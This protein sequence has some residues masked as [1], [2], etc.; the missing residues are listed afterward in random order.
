MMLSSN[1]LV[2]SNRILKRDLVIVDTENKIVIDGSEMPDNNELYDENE[3]DD[4]GKIEANR[5]EKA[6]SSAE[7]I[8]RQAERQAEE[9][10]INARAT[11]T[12]ESTAIR[13]EAKGEAARLAAEAREL[14]YKEGLDKAFQ[15]GE[16]IKSNAEKVLR[17]AQN[18]RIRMQQDFE[19]EMVEL[20]TQIA[21]KLLG[22]IPELSPSIIVN[23]IKQGF[24]AAT[25][26]G[27]VKVYVSQQD[28]DAVLENQDEL[29][30]ITDG[31]VKLEIVKDL[32]LSPMDCVIETPFG[33]VDCSLGQQFEAIKASLS[34]ILNN[35]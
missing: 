6:R 17:D 15:E 34:Y 20:I 7:K 35:R 32:S 27:D 1:R 9:L 19:P 8:L 3:P 28:Y 21:E 31:S 29:M 11:A 5:E 22:K 18:E 33:N 30:A 16:V 23:L 24:A 14:G 10:L 4:G 26:S 12:A 25:I 13:S 2:R